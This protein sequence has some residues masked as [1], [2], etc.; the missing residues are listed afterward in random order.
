MSG[1]DTE[2]KPLPPTEHKL[3]KSREKGQ[4]ASSADFVGG[5][6]AAIGLVFIALT[7][8]GFVGLF[9]GTFQ[10]SLDSWFAGG[11]DLAPTFSSMIANTFMT[12]LPLALIVAASGA[13][14]NILHKKGI[15]FSLHPVKPDFSRIS[16][17]KGLQKLFGVR[18]FTEFGIAFVRVSLWFTVSVL[19]AWL[20]LPTL[21]GAAQCGIGCVAAAGGR[22]AVYMLIAAIIFLIIVGL[23]DLPVQF[24]LF[25][26]EQ[27]MSHTEFRRE[28]RDTQGAPEYKQRRRE[29]HRDA[30]SSL[31][32]LRAA[33][34]ILEGRG[35]A[36]ALRY[37][38]DDAPVP[39]VVAKGQGVHAER[40]IAA[41]RKAGMAVATDGTL[42]GS[43]NE[44]VSVGSPIRNDQFQPIAGI[45]LRLGLPIG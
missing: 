16:P 15:P 23:F 25:S 32:G 44:T 37:D 27:K 18:N 14:L 43:I 7:W 36:V 28:L 33:T 40:I 45:I 39:I 6:T 4:V 29:S 42:T 38:R 20:L 5:G 26:H 9:A 22:T 3:R 31:G 17:S 34:F 8:A 35:G 10:R 30:A 21:L 41:A 24:A 11:I 2:H 12:L 19:L 1:D 13:I